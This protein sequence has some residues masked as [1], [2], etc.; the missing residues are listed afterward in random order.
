MKGLTQILTL[1]IQQPKNLPLSTEILTL[2]SLEKQKGDSTH[3]VRGLRMCLVT[4]YY[5]HF[6]ELCVLEQATIFETL[7]EFFSFSSKLGFIAYIAHF[8]VQEKK[9]LK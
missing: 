1:N 7:N 2:T 9:I 5:F 3:A 6:R 8:C 4:S